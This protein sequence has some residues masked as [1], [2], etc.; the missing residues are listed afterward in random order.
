MKKDLL[1]IQR[2]KLLHRKKTSQKHKRTEER[3]W[4]T[5]NGYARIKLVLYSYEQ[6]IIR[7][8]ND[9]M[10]ALQSF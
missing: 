5:S 8:Q 10:N 9:E 7:V 1:F 3:L 4:E 2:T 6:F